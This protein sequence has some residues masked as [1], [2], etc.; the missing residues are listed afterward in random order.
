MRNIVES[1]V[2]FVEFNRIGIIVDVSMINIIMNINASLKL[3]VCINKLKINSS[4]WRKKNEDR[5]SNLENEEAIVRESKIEIQE[6]YDKI[7]YKI[8]WELKKHK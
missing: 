4:K 5:G 3:I 8:F 7:K 6:C 1:R 2:I